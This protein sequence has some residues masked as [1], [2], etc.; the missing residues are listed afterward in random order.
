MLRQNHFGFLRI[1]SPQLLRNSAECHFRPTPTFTSAKH[2]TKNAD[3]RAP[4]IH[5]SK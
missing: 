2:E 4:S 1:T 5:Q 3:I